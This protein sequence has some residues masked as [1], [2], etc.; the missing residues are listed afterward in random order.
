MT[1]G[2]ECIAWL[3]TRA[4]HEGTDRCVELVEQRE[5]LAHIF[6]IDDLMAFLE[7]LDQGIELA[8]LHKRFAVTMRLTLAVLSALFRPAAPLVKLSI[9]GTRP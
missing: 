2:L 8:E 6:E 9:A 7:L 1:A 3:A 4:G 5:L